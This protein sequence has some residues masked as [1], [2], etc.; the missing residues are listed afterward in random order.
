MPVIA[1]CIQCG[2]EF[3]KLGNSLTCSKECSAENNRAHVSAY[4]AAYRQRSDV[5]EKAS[6]KRLPTT[7]EIRALFDYDPDSGELRWKKREGSHPRARAFNTKY[8]GRQTGCQSTGGYLQVRIDG[9]L[10]SVHRI[11]WQWMTG[12]WPGSYGV[13]HKDGDPSNNKFN[14]LRLSS[15][16]EN[17]TNSRR[18]KNNTTTFQCVACG[19]SFERYG[20]GSG[21]ARTCSKAC[22]AEH[23]QARIRAYN[24][25]RKKELPTANEVRELLSYDYVS[26][27]LTWKVRVGDDQPTRAFNTKWAGR[28]AGS[29]RR[30]GYYRVPVY[31]RAFLAHQLAWVIM[32]GEWPGRGKHIDHID[33]DPSNNIFSNLRLASPSSNCANAKRSSNNTSGFKGTYFDK[34]RAQYAARIKVDRRTHFL[35]RFATVEEAADAYFAAAQRFFGPFARAA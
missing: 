23:R 1:K 26:G 31:N 18:P 17:K 10:Y 5:R 32:T 15:E 35:G 3:Q 24:A 29:K 12:E 11:I 4:C 22:R 7:E 13:D 33:G 2:S 30:D 19:S 14:N 34:Q 6:R 16:R 20:P 9:R 21:N 8:A 27:S 25:A 28:A